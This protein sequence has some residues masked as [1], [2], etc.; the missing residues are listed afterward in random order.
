MAACDLNLDTAAANHVFAGDCHQGEEPVD[1]ITAVAGASA[2]GSIQEGK[3]HFFA[4]NEH[5]DD[6]L[7]CLNMEG[8]VVSPHV[9][10]NLLSMQRLEANGWK[11][12]LSGPGNRY[13]LAPSGHRIELQH[14]SGLY[15][16][17]LA[18]RGE[19]EK[20][21]AAPTYQ[22]IDQLYDKYYELGLDH[23]ARDRCRPHIMCT[24]TTRVGLPAA[25]SAVANLHS[26]LF[27]FNKAKIVD[28]IRLHGSNFGEEGE[29][30]RAMPRK[31]A[32]A[33]AKE[34]TELS[35]GPCDS[36]NP[37]PRKPRSEEAAGREPG[38]VIHCDI[39]ILES[40][41]GING[42]KYFIHFM[43]D[44]TRY[45][46]VYPMK[47][48]SDAPACFESFVAEA[49]RQG[50]TVKALRSDNEKVLK[51]GGMVETLNELGVEPQYT[52][53][54]DP[55]AGGRHERIIETLWS[56]TERAL[57]GA[58]GLVPFDVWPY[59]VPNVARTYN[60]LAHSVTGAPPSKSW[61][62]NGMMDDLSR[63]RTVGATIWAY[64]S[65]GERKNAHS[66]RN[67]Q[68]LYIG[69]RDAHTAYLYD[70]SRD[71]VVERGNF[72]K[73]IEAFNADNT[74]LDLRLAPL[75]LD[76]NGETAT[77][78]PSPKLNGTPELLRRR[79]V[80]QF[81]IKNIIRAE[82]WI[83]ESCL[84]ATIHYR[85]NQN[86]QR[87]TF[88]AG[89]IMYATDHWPRLMQLAVADARAE[90]DEANA[91]RGRGLL[92]LATTP[93]YEHWTQEQGPV[94]GPGIIIDL[95]T[96]SDTCNI[97][98]STGQIT[99]YSLKDAI[100]LE[101]GD[102]WTTEVESWDATSEGGGVNGASDAAEGEPWGV[103]IRMGARGKKRSKEGA[104]ETKKGRQK[105]K[106]KA[107]ANKS[108]ATGSGGKTSKTQVEDAEAEDA[109]GGPTLR[110][111]S[112][113]RAVVM[114]TSTHKPISKPEDADPN[115]IMMMDNRENIYVPTDK[116]LARMRDGLLKSLYLESRAVEVNNLDQQN[117]YEWMRREDVPA[118]RTLVRS[119]TIY[120]LKW[121][122]LTGALVK[123][124]ARI[125]A[126]GFSQIY[127]VDFDETYAST[128]KLSTIRYF[129]HLVCKHDF[130]MHEWDITAAY[131]HAPLKEDIYMMPPE[132][133]SRK[134][135]DGKFMI[136]KL[137]KALYGLRQSGH[138][139]MLTLFEW[140]RND[141]HMEQS[142]SDTSLWLWRND[143]SSLKMVLFV[144]TD[145]G[146]IAFKEIAVRN[147][148]MR[149]LCKRFN[150][151]EQTSEITRAF[152]IRIDRTMG[153]IRLNQ[154]EYVADLARLH[155]IKPNA[156]V[157]Q[158][159]DTGFKMEL[160]VRA[161]GDAPS[162]HQKQFLSILASMMWVGRCTR[163]DLMV[164]LVILGQ[165][166][167]NPSKSHLDALFR[168]VQYAL[169]TSERS[170]EF[171]KPTDNTLVVYSDAN[172]GTGISLNRR[173]ITG[174]LVVIGGNLIDWNCNHQPFVTTSSTD[175]EVIGNA[176]SA[177]IM[178][179]WQQKI[180]QVEGRRPPSTIKRQQAEQPQDVLKTDSEPSRRFLSQPMHNS[181]MRHVNIKFLFVR[182]HV[183]ANYYNLE[184]IMGTDNPAD[185][186]TKPLGRDQANRL[187]NI[188]TP[189][190]EIAD[191]AEDGQGSKRKHL[192]KMNG[193]TRKRMRE[194][195]RPRKD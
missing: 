110:R 96:D 155:G 113:R 30:I 158:G 185:M 145:D 162:P 20:F 152:N 169:N 55:R 170:L 174:T 85:D 29:K 87:W 53:P 91:G 127:G 193:K 24:S 50:R 62:K 77:V 23:Q 54:Y 161:E 124:K 119:M 49:R 89:I 11:L 36:F 1:I 46:K 43:D 40:V 121:D 84:S 70:D 172:F 126:R 156:K 27:H 10:K 9:I 131:L 69:M 104:V 136:W 95:N 176:S 28:S 178:R 93:E 192:G 153:R 151:G 159:M 31:Q 32:M 90:P 78:Y 13:L 139:W 167:C 48:K 117:V 188:I 114:M 16:I 191:A 111:S 15:Y 82:A 94:M 105:A 173:S 166:S 88:A 186:L 59:I 165:A 184:H 141:M 39:K 116:E 140:L 128:P 97:G 57:H 83:I 17:P 182:E 66:A 34:V 133:I 44:K 35:C 67:R 146:K 135:A 107:A 71:V 181:K 115:P 26:R 37:R 47:Q 65:E 68:Y 138:E 160:E 183:A 79:V 8:V 130:I 179:Y 81:G 2:E 112:R 106:A 195:R 21:A 189:L 76:V 60:N 14:A 148:F 22:G 33:I 118:G 7:C 171:A 132:G 103:A 149:R 190:R 25:R 6:R 154:K 147:E 122:P 38:D 4:Q 19:R 143:D 42:E 134:S 56:H 144:H 63:Q 187:Y 51:E 5:N 163:W 125:V 86:R 3:V 180:E 120:A 164:Y 101:P 92:R 41:P 52:P 137:I 108:S 142:L 157:Q 58:K 175:A 100:F 177:S 194:R 73:T 64:V 150:V 99:E 109:D 102:D 72:T 168:V 98:W 61:K 75:T 80:K 74:V 45:C 123:A 12:T 18:R 129:M